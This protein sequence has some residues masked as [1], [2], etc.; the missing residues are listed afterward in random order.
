MGATANTISGSHWQHL[1][2][3]L[4]FSFGWAHSATAQPHSREPVELIVRPV[5]NA[6]STFLQRLQNP[7]AKQSSDSLFADVLSSRPALQRTDLQKKGGTPPGPISAVT[8]VVRDS[9]VLSDVQARFQEHSDVQYVQPN[10]EYSVDGHIG[11]APSSAP[12]PDSVLAPENVFADSLDHLNVVRALEGWKVSAGTSSVSIG[13]VDTGIY[14]D[15]PDLADQFWGN[16]S[17]D[18]NGNR[19][20]DASDRNGTDDDGNGYVDDVVGYDFVDRPH[21]IEEGEYEER[22]P[23]PS[24]DSTGPFS[25]HG[26]AVAGILSAAAADASAGM[27]GVAPRTRLVALRAFG[28]DGRGRTDDIAAAIV[29]G[30]SQGVD[31][32]NLSFGRDR[33]APL[34]EEAIEFAVDQGTV[35]VASAGN[36]GAIDAPHYPSDYPEVISVMWLAED[37]DGVPDFSRSQHGIGVDLGAP[38]SS[39]F[40]TQYP[41][42]R[43]LNEQPI[44]R[45]DLYGPSN[46]SSFSAPQVA[47]AAALLR[48]VDPTLSPI[49]VRSI[50]TATAADINRVSWSH[51]T[52]AGR[53]DVARSLLRSYP[54]QTE[55]HAPEHNE[56]FVGTEPLPVVGTSLDPS[57]Q[58]YR[59]YYATGTENLDTRPDPWVAITPPRE[60]QAYRDTLGTWD[61]SSLSEGT[62]TLRLVTTLVDGRTVEDRRRVVIDRSPPEASVEFLGP[63][64]VDGHWGILADISSDD[65]VQSLM[66]VDIRGRTHRVDGEFATSRQG[67][68]WTNERGL[69]GE[70]SVH[71]I[72]TNRSGLQTNLERTVTVPR[73]QSNPSFFQRTDTDLPNGYLLPEAT[74][75]DEDDLPEVLL[76]PFQNGGLS[77]TLRAFEWSPSGFAST[78]TLLARLIPKDVGDTNGDGDRELLLQVR[79]ATVLLEQEGGDQI[80]RHLLYADTTAVSPSQD[81]PSLYGALLTHLDGDDEGEIVGNWKAPS[82]QTEWRVLERDGESFELIARL[83]NPTAH[84]G[85]DTTRT[86][87]NAASGDFDGDGRQDLLVG[88]GDGDWIVYESTGND[89]FEV[90]WTHETDRFGADRRFAVGDMTGNAR[91]EFVTHATYHPTSIGERESEPPITYYSIWTAT[92]ENEYEHLFRFPVAGTQSGFGAMTTA[93]FDGDDRDEVA[94]AHPPSLFVLD[95]SS[96]GDVQ[97]LHQDRGRPAV[98]SPALTAA[99]FDGD[100]VPSLLAATTEETVRRFVV[101]REGLNHPPPHWVEALPTGPSGSHLIWR[102]AE[103]DSVT[104]YG[105]SPGGPLDPIEASSD[106]STTISGTERRRFALRAWTNGQS[107]PLSPERQVR[108]HF[109]ATVSSMDY[110]ASSSVRLRFS[111]PLEPN[112]RPRQFDLGSHGAPRSIV[113]SNNGTG[114]ILR[115][116]GTVAG[117]E[118]SLS[119]QNLADTSGLAV[120]QTEVSVTFPASESRSL[121]VEDVEIVGEQQVHLTFSAPLDGATAR[122]P[123]NYSVR[124]HGVVEQVRAEDPTP[125]EVTVLLDGIVAGATGQEAALTVSSLRS[126]NGATLVDEGSTVRLA[127]PADDL[128]NVYVYPNPIE[129]SRHDLQLTIA[130]LPGT[131]EVRIYSPSGRLVQQLSVEEGRTGGTIWDLRDRRG[132]RVPSGIYLIRVNAPEASPVLK[133]AAVIR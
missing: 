115:F 71:V 59:L 40:T 133:K 46:G 58:R 68:T 54:A 125:S 97:V 41:R 89:A 124:P 32:L 73:G 87:P 70:A 61:V 81:G 131:A 11:S 14:L 21:T 132:E 1:F 28:G 82:A 57:F 88:D 106:S 16:A 92:G 114:V 66:T 5:E 122:D 48:S 51:T 103:T 37:G 108:P 13:V 34:L 83:E 118:R 15:H 94:I 121:F 75:L 107:S 111:E 12:D 117:L 98:R 96:G 55:L 127:Q 56:G 119:W 44:R 63:G 116:P 129:Y 64:H 85:P 30:A 39:V 53:L 17:E 112:L 50:L 128:S 99:D 18:L 123:G 29:Y 38:G 4:L 76:N 24:P 26:T 90:A 104:V 80:P 36:E 72:L 77:D 130:G 91:S 84:D 79:G 49:S 105:G 113:R 102:A 43:I 3:I 62:Y 23:D 47:G 101:N 100:G 110:P 19:R 86:S 31:V 60:I 8:L 93:D 6:S 22:D 2:W 25:G 7:S 67:L 74:D 126:V 78:D 9:S 33:P 69:G 10:I 65:V 45:Q 95:A 109:A 52:G 20:L 42:R 120:G 27:V 35:V